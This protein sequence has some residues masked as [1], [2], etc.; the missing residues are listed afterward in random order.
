MQIKQKIKAFNLKAFVKTPVGR[1][2]YSF[3]K[4]YLTV[5]LV[6]YLKGVAGETQECGDIMLLNM[7][8]IIPA[9]KWSFIAVLRNIYKLLTE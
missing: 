8:V 3:K 9:L 7:A 5:F 1:H 6:L 2:I 4:T